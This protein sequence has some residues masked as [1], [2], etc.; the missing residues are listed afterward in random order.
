MGRIAL[1][2]GASGFIGRVLA[3]ALHERGYA[4]R[5]LMRTAVA[6]PWDECVCCD[7]SSGTL[8]PALL[9]GVSVVFHL[10]GNAHAERPMGQDEDALHEATT[11]RGTRVLLDAVR[12]AGT[13]SFVFF[14]SVKAMGEGT[15]GEWD[16]SMTPRP[17]TP[18][19]RARLAGEQAVSEAGRITDLHVCNLRLPMV[20]GP[21][22]RGNLP[23]M[24]RAIDRGR[25]PSLPETGNRRSMVHVDD[26]V[27]AALLAAGDV[28]ARG[29]TYLVTDGSAY[30]TRDI[31]VLI[32]MALGKR[33]PN[34]TVPWTLLHAA[35]RTGDWLGSVRGKRVLFDSTVLEKLMGSAWYSSRR[36][37][38][39]LGYQPTKNLRD[40]IEAMVATYR[41]AGK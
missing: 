23:R 2:T 37:T 21:G 10:A 33:P 38:T 34:L 32:Y 40:G 13:R 35:A 27:Q 8:S 14:S 7:L 39:E 20:Y 15:Q 19:G 26:V 4:V 16:E 12:N 24:I 28:R 11:V 18:Y 36:I 25:F 41:Q 6:G 9:E 5:G 29:Q 22:G 3:R 17:T 30:S 1:V 31:A